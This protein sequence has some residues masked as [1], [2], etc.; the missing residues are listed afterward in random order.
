VTVL[1]RS[2]AHLSPEAVL[3]RGYAIVTAKDGAIVEDAA[4][5]AIGDDVELAFA[6]GTAGATIKRV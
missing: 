6:R 2:L 4:R 1:A 5:L 3:D